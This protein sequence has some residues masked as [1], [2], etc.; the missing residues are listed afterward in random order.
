MKEINKGIKSSLIIGFISS[1]TIT[2]LLFIIGFLYNRFSIDGGILFARTG[3][4]I[5]LSILLL[6]VAGLI[7]SKKNERPAKDKVSWEKKFGKLNIAF[8]IILI[9]LP[10]LLYAIGLDYLTF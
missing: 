2:F 10:F 3:S 1:S 8:V 4:L 6:V 9:S 7:L 5:T